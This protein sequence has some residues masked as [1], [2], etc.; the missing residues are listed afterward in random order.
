MQINNHGY[1]PAALLYN[2]VIREM[3]DHVEYE[4]FIARTIVDNE[5]TQEFKK[6]TEEYIFLWVNLTWIIDHSRL[7][8]HLYSNK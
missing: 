1:V 2:K 8:C 4:K 5:I 6:N 3:R 7:N